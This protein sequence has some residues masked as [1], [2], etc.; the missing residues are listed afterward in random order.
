LPHRFG[1]TRTASISL[2]FPGIAAV[3]SRF[4]LG[5][6]AGKSDECNVRRH[7][8]GGAAGCHSN[9]RHKFVPHFLW[10]PAVPSSFT[11]FLFIFF[12]SSFLFSFLFSFSFSF[13]FFFFPFL[14]FILF[15]LFYFF[16]FFLFWSILSGLRARRVAAA[17]GQGL[18][19]SRETGVSLSSRK[20]V[21]SKGTED[22]AFLICSAAQTTA[23]R[24]TT[25]FPSEVPMPHERYSLF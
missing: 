18:T 11:F 4:A 8:G 20:R 13:F 24:V 9:S 14:F 25:P 10:G 15:F 2:R 3:G 23:P 17:R 12:S 19:A 22:R 1:R 16:F 6:K 7:W 5:V 21:R